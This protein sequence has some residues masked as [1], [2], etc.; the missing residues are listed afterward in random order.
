MQITVTIEEVPLASPDFENPEL[1]EKTRNEFAFNVG[2]AIQTALHHLPNSKFDPATDGVT[3]TVEGSAPYPEK[4]RDEDGFII[5][6]DKQRVDDDGNLIDEEG[7]H[8]DIA[9]QRLDENEDPVK[10]VVARAKPQKSTTRKTATPTAR[11][12]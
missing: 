3:V 6:A 11:K 2:K 1:E 8:I 9:G 5:N 12:K 10:P 4:E 7:Y